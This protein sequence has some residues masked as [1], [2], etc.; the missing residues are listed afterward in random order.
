MKIKKYEV[1]SLDQ[2]G[3]LREPNGFT[4]SEVE[5]LGENQHRI[6]INDSMFTRL[7]KKK[8][9][10]FECIDDPTINVYT[11]DNCWGSGVKYCLYTFKNKKAATIKKEIEAK[12]QKRFGYFLRGIDLS[13]IKEPEQADKGAL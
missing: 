13:M 11:N 4:I 2:V 9:S 8:S 10:V 1:I 3:L 6:V 7:E 5:I 12:I